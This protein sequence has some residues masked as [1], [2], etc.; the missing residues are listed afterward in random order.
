[1]F[2]LWVK[3]EQQKKE[4]KR[5]DISCEGSGAPNGAAAPP[6]R[7]VEK[8]HQVPFSSSSSR[9]QR[10]PL[11]FGG[12]AARN[13]LTCHFTTW[14]LNSPCLILPPAI[15]PSVK[16]A[17][18]ASSAPSVRTYGAAET[19]EDAG[20]MFAVSWPHGRFVLNRLEESHI[21]AIK[22]T[23]SKKSFLLGGG[24]TWSRSG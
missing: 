23:S 2:S 20:D 10:L 22:F 24:A 17:S 11:N 16:W 8:A 5:K 4:K 3:S 1:M 21:Q 12:T 9:R 7:H 18:D 13:G 6:R 14:K 15:V 19:L